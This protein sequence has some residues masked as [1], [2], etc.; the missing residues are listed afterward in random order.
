MRRGVALAV[1]GAVLASV[2][3]AGFL[4]YYLYQHHLSSD[5]KRTLVAAMDPHCSV[6]DVQQYLHAAR[7]LVRTKRDAEVL[8]Q[9]QEAFEMAADAQQTA[10]FLQQNPLQMLKQVWGAELGEETW[11]MQNDAEDR[12]QV[13]ATKL[14][15]QVRSELGMPPL[16]QR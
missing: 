5:L 7:P 13:E 16:P 2:C 11:K 14:F 12:E 15:N 4:G 10:Q 6:A 3:L 9:T 1:A 8:A